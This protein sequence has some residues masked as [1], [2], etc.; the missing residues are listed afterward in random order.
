MAK[1]KT[2]GRSDRQDPKANK[3]LAIRMVLKETPKANFAD[4]ASAVKEKY[5]HAISPNLYY[6]LK[7]KSNMKADRRR[8]AN[9]NEAPQ[10][11]APMNSAATWVEAIKLAQRLLKAT[12]D[13]NNATALLKAV[14]Q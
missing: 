13:I 6:T 2:S 9:A 7:A 11:P 14:E 10:A 5:G 1:K 12:G 3:S 4:V 8:R